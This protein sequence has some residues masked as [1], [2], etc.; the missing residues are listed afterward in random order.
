M[1]MEEMLYAL[2][3]IVGRIDERQSDRKRQRMDAFVGGILRGIGAMIG[4]ALMGTVGVWILQYLAE[5]NLPVISD[6]L[7]EVVTM[8]RMRI[9]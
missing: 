3:Q 2:L 9:Q 6:F 1:S 8:V 4:V 5:R 7:A